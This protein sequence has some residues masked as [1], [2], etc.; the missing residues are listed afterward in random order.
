MKR[1]LAICGVALMGGCAP[2]QGAFTDA[3]D[4]L[5]NPPSQVWEAVK[6]L[7]QFVIDLIGGFLAD[8]VGK[9]GL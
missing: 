9:I 7:L 3:K 6:Y 4:T 5:L 2:I 1:F 8:V